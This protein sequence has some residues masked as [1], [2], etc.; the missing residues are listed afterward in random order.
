MTSPH[1]FNGA[2]V[3]HVPYSHTRGVL[4]S[5]SLPHPAATSSLQPAHDIAIS[6]M[7][8]NIRYRRKLLT[9]TSQRKRRVDFFQPTYCQSRRRVLLQTSAL[10]LAAS[11]RYPVDNRLR[12]QHGDCASDIAGTAAHRGGYRRGR[13]RMR[14]DRGIAR[15]DARTDGTRG[16]VSRS[17]E[18]TRGLGPHT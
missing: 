18:R 10:V 1:A 9:T 4:Q 17:D 6:D 2:G 7:H 3:V 8:A 11:T 13:P 12:E 15:F 16:N 5:P 14:A